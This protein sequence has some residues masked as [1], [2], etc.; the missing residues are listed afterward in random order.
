MYLSEYRATNLVIMQ[1]GDQINV[2]SS[3]K[4]KHLEYTIVKC[5]LNIFDCNKV[6]IEIQKIRRSSRQIILVC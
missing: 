4:V 3:E 5:V 6:N 1:S 2:G